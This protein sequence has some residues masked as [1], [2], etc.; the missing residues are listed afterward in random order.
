VA[1]DLEG[2]RELALG[3]R[4]RIVKHAATASIAFIHLRLAYIEFAQVLVL[5]TPSTHPQTTGKRNAH[6]TF[7]SDCWS[8]LFSHLL[9]CARDRPYQLDVSCL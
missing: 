1:P 9:V 5:L 6:C 2:D 7:S 3:T 4:E 8:S